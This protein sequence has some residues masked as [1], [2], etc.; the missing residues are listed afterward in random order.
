MVALSA[1]ESAATP[2][3]KNSTNF[4]TTPTDRKCWKEI[5]QSVSQS[6]N[7]SKFN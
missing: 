4:P 7:Q 5:N 1:I 3:P 2:G 6:V